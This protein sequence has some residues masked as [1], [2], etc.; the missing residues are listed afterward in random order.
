[1]TPENASNMELVTEYT[2]LQRELDEENERWL[3]LSEEL[4]T[5]NFELWALNFE[6]WTLNIAYIGNHNYE[7]W[8]LNSE[9]K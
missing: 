3:I 4:E 8:I 2:N 6:L 1:M 9:L 7:F 5:L